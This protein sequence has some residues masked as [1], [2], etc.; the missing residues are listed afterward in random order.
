VRSASVPRQPEPSKTALIISAETPKS[1]SSSTGLPT[2]IA[3]SA[4]VED[5]VTSPRAEASACSIGP[6]TKRTASGVTRCCRTRSAY[7]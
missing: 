2:A 6:A 7:S 5:T 4:A 3:S 1:R